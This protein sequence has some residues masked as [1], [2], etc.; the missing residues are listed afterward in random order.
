ME[1]TLTQ[2]WQNWDICFCFGLTEAA[3][4]A[5]QWARAVRVGGTQPGRRIDDHLHVW[6]LKSM[7]DNDQTRQ[8]KASYSG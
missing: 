6:A 8:E 5:E 7:P 3:E 4:A 1:Y 2:S